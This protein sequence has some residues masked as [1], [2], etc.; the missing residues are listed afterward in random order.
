MP[1]SNHCK[2]NSLH[3]K[4]CDK[5]C[6]HKYYCWIY[7]KSKQPVVATKSHNLKAP[8]YRQG[9]P[10]SSLQGCSSLVIITYWMTSM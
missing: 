9:M 5:P 3:I 10:V 1:L 4:H 6:F 2:N 8:S 7:D